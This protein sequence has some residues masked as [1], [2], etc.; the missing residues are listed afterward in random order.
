MPNEVAPMV[1]ELNALIEH[2]EKQAEEA[3]RHAGNLAMRSRPR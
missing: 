2:N 3:R 1:E